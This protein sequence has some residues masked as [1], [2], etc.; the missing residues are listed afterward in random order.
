MR[1]L[2]LRLINNPEDDA[3]LRVVNFPPRGIG[4]ADRDN[5]QAVS[6][7]P[8][9]RYGRLPAGRRGGRAQAASGHSSLFI[10]GMRIATK[11]LAL[12][13]IVRHPFDAAR[14][15]QD[16]PHATEKDGFA[17]LR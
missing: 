2:I 17:G 8:G 12:P 1:W 16:A 11:N 6:W 9:L 15:I 4:F 10:E 7:A 3:L 5:L 13:E 14:V